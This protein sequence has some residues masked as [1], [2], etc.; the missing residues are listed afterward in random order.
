MDAARFTVEMS[1][2]TG[3]SR[4]AGAFQFSD[5]QDPTA[6]ATAAS[7]SVTRTS[8][9]TSYGDWQSMTS[10]QKLFVRF[11]VNVDQEDSGTAFDMCN[12]TIRVDTK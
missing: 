3:N 9:G 6:S 8:N 7:P 5:T 4:I 1:Q 12:A 2:D 10:G 11:G